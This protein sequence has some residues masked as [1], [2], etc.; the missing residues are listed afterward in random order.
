M[1]MYSLIQNEY[2]KNVHVYEVG[3][4]NEHNTEK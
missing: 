4:G 2:N 3:S 1:S